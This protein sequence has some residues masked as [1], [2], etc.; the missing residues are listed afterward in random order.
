MRL[1]SQGFLRPQ[2]QLGVINAE[3]EDAKA[4]LAEVLVV[5]AEN[6]KQR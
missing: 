5:A 6:V 3:N 2:P 4:V 1:G